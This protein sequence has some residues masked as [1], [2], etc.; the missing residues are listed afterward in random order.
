MLQNQISRCID[1]IQER[2]K[3]CCDVRYDFGIAKMVGS[4]SP[5]VVCGNAHVILTFIVVFFS[6]VVSNTYCVVFLFCV[7]SSM[8]PVSLDCQFVIVPSIF[9]NVYLQYILLY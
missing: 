1:Y 7:S 3:E 8:L 9:F 2:Y 6:I 4:V 5:P